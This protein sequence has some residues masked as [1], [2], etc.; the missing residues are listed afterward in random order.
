M[1]PLVFTMPAQAPQNGSSVCYGCCLC[2]KTRADGEPASV[3]DEK[4][5]RDSAGRCGLVD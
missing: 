2:S 5:A 3:T 1:K 4:P